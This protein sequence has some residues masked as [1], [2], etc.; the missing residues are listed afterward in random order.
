MSLLFM[1]II[2]QLKTNKLPLPDWEL[3]DELF[4]YNPYKG[5]LIWKVNRSNV[6][7][8]S[9][10]GSKHK[11]GNLIYL[12][13]GVN[14]KQYSVQRIIWKLYLK[15]DP[16]HYDIDHINRN[17]LDNRIVN[18]RKVTTKQNNN[19]KNDYKNSKTGFSGIYQQD[20]GRYTATI[21]V[22]GKAYRNGTHETIEQALIAQEEKR[23]ELKNE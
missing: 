7:K 13:V 9:I 18:L 11:S 20:N 14:G 5:D 8:G 22:N 16:K 19:N 21:F 2:K 6:K 15:E 1:E 10:A 3:L 4:E 12:Q 23:K 17:T